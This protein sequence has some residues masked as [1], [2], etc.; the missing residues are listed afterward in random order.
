MVQDS[1]CSRKQNPLPSYYI[2]TDFEGSKT[3]QHSLRMPKTDRTKDSDIKIRG[4]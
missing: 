1:K 4:V 2:T 3:L